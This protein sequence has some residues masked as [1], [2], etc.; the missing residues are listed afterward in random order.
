MNI[1]ILNID[2]RI[3]KDRTDKDIDL[4]FANNQDHHH[5]Q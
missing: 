4:N 3:D 5:F 2:N 1:Y